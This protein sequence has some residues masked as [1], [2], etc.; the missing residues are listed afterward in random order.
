MSLTYRRMTA[1]DVPAAL[2]VR[3][4]TRENAV[5]LDELEEEYGVTPQSMADDLRSHAGGWVCEDGGKLV[6]FSMGNGL[7][8]EIAVVAVAP[9][10]ERRGIGKTVLAHTQGWLF[11]LGHEEIWLLANPDP[12]VRATGFYEK[13]G[14]KVT[15]VMKGHDRVLKLQST[16]ANDQNV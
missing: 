7:N 8:G 14:W 15:G 3:L 11:S 9:E 2:T 16:A 10:Y 1:E 12:D 5:T 4:S 6:G 13:L